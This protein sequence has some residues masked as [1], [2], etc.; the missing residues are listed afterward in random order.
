MNMDMNEYL[1]KI[2]NDANKTANEV[3]LNKAVKD[4]S[5]YSKYV[6][7]MHRNLYDEFRA[8]GYTVA[9]SERLASEILNRL[10]NPST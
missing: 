10:M 6:A 5:I 3:E 2:V 8:T 7:R 1:N 4:M 9:Q